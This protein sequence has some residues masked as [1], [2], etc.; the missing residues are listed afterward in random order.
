MANDQKGAILVVDDDQLNRMVMGKYLENE[1]HQVFFAINGV[2]A[3]KKLA[4]Q[5][6][7]MLLLD[8]EMPEMDG[9]E[10]LEHMLG[11]S[12]LRDIPVIV[13]S[14]IEQIDSVVRC[15]EMGAED[16]LP[17]PVDRVLLKARI[18]ASLEKKHLRDQQSKLLNQL[19]R[20][21]DIARETQLSILPA[22]LPEPEG[23]R[24]GAK[25]I[26]AR[27]V[28]GDFYDVIDLGDQRWGVVIGD[29]ADKGLPAAL[30]M[31]LTYSLLR[32]EASRGT[33]PQQALLNVN[34]TLMALNS[35]SMFVTILCGVLD[36]K[37]GN[38]SFARAGHPAPLVLTSSG[39]LIKIPLNRSH[40][41]GL[42]EEIAVD[43][44]S[45]PVPKGGLILIY[46]DGLSEASNEV[47][48]QFGEAELRNFLGTYR[49]HHPQEI[50]EGLW[51]AVQRFCGEQPQ[52]DDFTVVAIK[53]K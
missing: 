13:T 5:T 43:A 48:E 46:S 53:S 22:H 12:I 20:E 25:M 10:V 8:I 1:G 18:D 14:A 49:H 27:A 44:Q 51:L 30:F 36:C 19:E 23:F 26:P 9:Y 2:D 37:Q 32:A 7:D 6:F 11:D 42:F 3:L 50:C 4:N 28:G 15:I 35:A 52:Q 39:E 21:M 40:A 24:L 17:K 29:V 34:R 31:T 45:F 47:G 16:Y 38:F 41:I 33:P